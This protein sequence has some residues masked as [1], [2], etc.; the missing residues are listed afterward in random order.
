MVASV[1]KN[2]TFYLSVRISKGGEELY[3]TDGFPET[4]ALSNIS[5][6]VCDGRIVSVD[7]VNSDA[8][9]HAGAR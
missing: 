2:I 9:I 1:S 8:R 3:V 4:D 6:V 7:I 5:I